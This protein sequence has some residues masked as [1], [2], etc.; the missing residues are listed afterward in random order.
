[1]LDG[2][3]VLSFNFFFPQKNLDFMQNFLQED[4][5]QADVCLMVAW[6]LD[7][8]CFKASTLLPG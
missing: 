2:L 3:D 5:V 4:L 7:F 6:K 8:M 1:M